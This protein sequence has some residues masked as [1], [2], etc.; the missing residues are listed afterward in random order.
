MAKRGLHL[1]PDIRRKIFLQRRIFQTLGEFSRRGQNPHSVRGRRYNRTAGF[2]DLLYQHRI[3]R[4]GSRR[5]D[6]LK[7]IYTRGECVAYRRFLVQVSMD[8][9]VVPVG[10]LDDG[11][12]LIESQPA[13]QLDDV[14]AALN[15][16]LRGSR[17]L[18]GR[19][20][21]RLAHRREYRSFGDQPWAAD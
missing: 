20:H 11:L 19:L 5:A 3:V 15:V 21:D 13:L 17:R 7:N 6:V 10:N 8:F 9:H 2:S 1:C 12:V 18:G 4:S 16:L 14:R